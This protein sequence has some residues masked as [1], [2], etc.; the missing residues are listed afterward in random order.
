MAIVPSRPKCAMRT[1][2]TSRLCPTVQRAR[3]DARGRVGEAVMR[4]TVR[5][6]GQTKMKVLLQLRRDLMS[7]AQSPKNRG[8]RRPAAPH[9][10]Q[11]DGHLP[12]KRRVRLSL[13][14]GLSLQVADG[15]ID[16]RSRKA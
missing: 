9:R 12:N 3:R 16:L 5:P 1:S 8:A 13:F 6:L 7:V 14:G 4:I 11:A 15:E 10:A 2:W